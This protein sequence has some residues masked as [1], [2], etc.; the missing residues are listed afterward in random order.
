[1]IHIDYETYSPTDLTKVGAWKYV[2]SEEA[3]I[4]IAAISN[5][6]YGPYLAV[7]PKYSHVVPSDPRALALL[8]QMGQHGEEIWA[9]N[10]PF[11]MAVS[12]ALLN[13]DFGV[14]CPRRAQWRCTALLCRRAGLPA[15]LDKACETLKLTQKKDNRGGA[16][17]KQ[18]SCPDKSGFRVLPQ[19]D[20]I[21]FQEY[22]DYCLQD[23][24]SEMGLH[25]ALKPF[26]PTGDLL[27][28][29]TWDLTV[30]ARGF[31]V[32]VP[33]CKAA[34]KIIEELTQ[35]AEEKFFKLTGVL[36]SQRAKAQSW[37]YSNGLP[38]ENM[39]ADTIEALLEDPPI[40]VNESVIDTL[41][42]YSSQQFAAVKK[43]QTMLDCAMA[44]GR[45]RGGLQFHG[46]APGKWSG[47][48]VQPQNFKK[49]EKAHR[50]ITGEF[51]E[52]LKAGASR[53]TLEMCYGNP[54]AVMSSSIRH[55]I[56]GPLLDADYAAIE[57]RIVPWLAG[58]DNVLERFR[59]GKDL[60]KWM[61]SSI[62]GIPESAVDVDQRTLGKVTILG[63]GFQMWWPKFQATA[64]TQYS[65]TISDELAKKAV[66]AY[67]DLCDK[68]VALWGLL[69]EAVRAAI[70]SPGQAFPAG[71]RISA[72]VRKVGD[73]PFL[74]LKLPSGRS[75][76][77]PWPALEVD[78]SRPGDTSISF[79]G[80]LDGN[81]WGR[82]FTFG[83]SLL[84]NC[85]TGTAFDLM[86]YGGMNAE[87]TGFE[88]TN[89]IHDQ[90]LADWKP[91]QTVERFVE[92]LTTLPAWADGLPIKAEGNITPYYTK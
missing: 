49:P 12:E 71:R 61:A 67:R 74:L 58:Q 45:V 8:E 53:E 81:T 44:D 36:P 56:S 86:A 24:R 43:V 92:C 38:L 2:E 57:A 27:R 23:V 10:A 4:L 39:Q 51:F 14:T 16:L 31:A 84:E 88:V 9:H 20:P 26:T 66:L 25:K 18:F 59:S 64:L 11:E 63:C 89:L 6:G 52:D 28:A 82:V 13:H 7:N 73:V 37:F 87:A 70:T 76:A 80:N 30:N 42:L 3:E 5:D 79:F 75:L 62:Y 72:C 47:R 78:P 50:E 19:D 69:E 15:S 68:V 90:A 34:Q 29:F 48:L 32:D 22:C 83:G 41:K 46:A 17:I 40:G 21:A 85:T 1:M 54:L 91:G 55:F 77:Y 65:L 35:E 60:Y 33:A